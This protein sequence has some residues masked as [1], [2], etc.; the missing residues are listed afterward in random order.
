[1]TRRRLRPDEVE[2]WR[3]VA[4]TAQRLHPERK[5]HQTPQPK[6]KPAKPPQGQTRITEFTMGQVTQPITGKHDL[7]PSL[8]DTLDRAPV[9]MDRKTHGRMRKGKLVPEARIDLHGMTLDRAHGALNRFI[10]TQHSHGRRLVLVITGKGKDRD[11]HG[12][13]PVR[14]GLLKHQVPQW[15][16]MPPLSQAVLQITPAHISHGGD[17][18]YYVYLRRHR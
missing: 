8:R 5:T 1:M 15:L 6:P 18:A 12:P 9:A 14:R 2:L 3:K 4:E 11:G 16:S 7:A 17:G 10:L 13:I